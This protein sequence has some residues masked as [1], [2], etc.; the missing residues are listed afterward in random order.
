[1]RSRARRDRDRRGVW[2]R[3]SRFIRQLFS[4]GPSSDFEGSDFEGGLGVR[5]PRQPLRPILSG[6]AAL[7]PPPTET[8]DVWAVGEE[9]NAG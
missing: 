6:A 4:S 3:V 7:E 5:E 9:D 2:K 8:R 1:M